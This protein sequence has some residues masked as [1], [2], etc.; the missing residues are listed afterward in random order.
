MRRGRIL[1]LVLFLIGALSGVNAQ[2]LTVSDIEF[3]DEGYNHEH[4]LIILT[5]EGSTLNVQL[6]N[7]SAHPY[8]EEFVITP[9]MSG[10]SDG[11]PCSVSIG[12]SYINHSEA[13]IITMFNVSFNVHGIEAN[14]FYFSCWWYR[15][16]VSLTEGEPLELWENRN[17]SKDGVTYTL[18]NKTK[19]ATL[20]SG[21][22][23]EGEYNIPSELDYG[24]Q[25]FT[26]TSINYPAFAFNTS[27]TSVIIPK[28]VTNIGNAVFYRCSNLTDVYCYAENVPETGINV[29]NDSPI[30]SATLHVPAGSIDKYKATEPWSGFG[31]IVAT[32]S[33]VQSSGCLN[34]TRAGSNST[35]ESISLLKEGN[36]LTV[37]LHNYWSQCATEDFEVTPS[38]SESNNGDPYTVSVKV[39]SIGENEADC[40]CPYNISFTIHGVEADS[41]YFDCWWFKG[42]VNLTEGEPWVMSNEYYPEG[43]KWTEIRLD[44]LKYDSWYSKVGDEWVPNYETIEYYVKGEHENKYW[45]SPFKCVYTNGPEWTDSLTLLIYEGK[46]YGYDMGILATVPVPVDDDLIPWPGEAYYFDWRVGMTVEF[47][48]ITSSNTTAIY[49]P[50]TF[51]FGQIEEIKEGD[52]GGVRPLKYTD[53]NG[54]RIIQGIGVTTWNDGEC[55][56]GPVEPYKMAYTI[57][58]EE[59]NYRSM[60]VHFER[61]GEVLYDAW[62]TKEIVSYTKDQMAT[63]ILPT[64]P[65]ANKGKY[66]RLD[67]CEDGKIIFTEEFHPKAKVPYIIVPNEDFNIDLNTLDLEGL[68][69]SSVSVGGVSFIGSYNHAEFNC[70]EGYYIDIIDKTTDCHVDDANLKMVTIGALRAYLKV[71]WDDPYRQGGTRGV[72]NK[73]AIVLEDNPNSIAKVKSENDNDGIY[74]LQGRRLLSKPAKGLYMQNG[75][76]FMVK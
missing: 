36:I 49:P 33:D 56:F 14:S 25:A 21:R 70:E 73:L 46:V 54:V 52:F 20:S 39:K 55:L 44:T 29:F 43:T 41:F 40:I 24:G 19:T 4:P 32:A 50:G 53:I 62:P 64:E 15:G 16:M 35:K 7:Y 5:K 57:P 11:E 66:Y 23:V 51:D 34:N 1:L 18:D 71:S 17:I 38:V 22:H 68:T 3:I 30:A 74:D 8:T 72:R 48:D 6:M 69:K 12:V 28:N 13:A 63:I 75:K 37:N 76:K 45:E 67:R 61:N 26:L 27:L 65:D 42:Q 9:K 58:Y 10:G 59:R 2:E 31:N 60:L 47:K